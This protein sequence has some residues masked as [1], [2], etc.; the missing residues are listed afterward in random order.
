MQIRPHYPCVHTRSCAHQMVVVVPVR[1]D[2]LK[3]PNINKKYRKHR[4]KRGE[5]T[6]SGH[7]YTENRNSNNDGHHSIAEC[8]ESCRSHDIYPSRKAARLASTQD[9]IRDGFVQTSDQSD[10][11][12]TPTR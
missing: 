5:G 11:R 10:N 9:E 8:F 4:Y 2:Y 7:P 1:A 3:T 12:Y 6:I